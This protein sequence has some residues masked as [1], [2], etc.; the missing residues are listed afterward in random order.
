MAPSGA[1]FL[2]SVL[3]VALLEMPKLAFAGRSS[4]SLPMN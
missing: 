4:Q 3:K 1:L 2:P